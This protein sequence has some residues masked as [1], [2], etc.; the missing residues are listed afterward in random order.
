MYKH[1]APVHLYWSAVFC[2]MYLFENVDEG[3]DRVHE[4]GKVRQYVCQD[5]CPRRGHELQPV[6]CVEVSGMAERFDG[7]PYPSSFT[8]KGTS[9]GVNE[10]SSFL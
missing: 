9:T 3:V 1:L 2:D 6:V 7:A 5:V 10:V 4:F 8:G